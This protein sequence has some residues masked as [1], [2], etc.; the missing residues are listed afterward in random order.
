MKPT[1]TPQS[2]GTKQMQG[3]E[4]WRSIDE[5]TEKPEFKN[6]LH[7]EF[8]EGASEAE[9]VNRRHFLKIM[10]ASFALAGAGAAGCRRPE[11]YILPYSR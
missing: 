4:Y 11:S 9:G 1:A 8:P 7:R 2:T 3:P 5:L 6:W 10:G